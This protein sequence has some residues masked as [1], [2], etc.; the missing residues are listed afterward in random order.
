MLRATTVADLP[1]VTD[2]EAGEDTAVW[3]GET[4]R[5]WHERALADPGQRHLIAEDTGIPAGFV[6][7]AGVLDDGAVELRRMV[8][9]P[10]FRGAGRGRELLRAAV[11]HA[12]RDLGAPAVWLDV[13]VDNLRARN[14]YVSEGF[15]PT[16]TIPDAVTEP[17]GTTSDLLV[18]TRDLLSACHAGQAE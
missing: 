8:I 17:D 12:R 2:W 18:M 10:R 3:L 1:R 6:V 15:T 11:L 4:G 13:K 5:S 7:L 9:S 16:R 14:L